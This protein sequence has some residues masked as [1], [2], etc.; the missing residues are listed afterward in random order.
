VNRPCPTEQVLLA[1]HQGTLPAGE[2]DA[3]ADHLESC[4]ACESAAQRLDASVDRVVAVVRKRAQAGSWTG[5]SRAMADARWLEVS[6]TD[7]T[8]W[9]K[10][11]GYEVLGLL[12]R[13]GMGIV[14]KARQVRLKRLVALK[15]LRISDSR[16]AARA[17]TEAEALARLTHPGIVQI[18]RVFEHAG[19]DYLALELVEGGSLRS[20]LD[21]KPLPPV[22]AATLIES[23][24]RAAHYAHSHDIVHRDLKPANILLP[25]PGGPGSGLGAPKIADFGVAKRLAASQGQTCDGD[26]LGTPAYMAPEQ[27]AGRGVDARSDVYSLGVILYELL[28]G[29]VPLQ[30]ETT[31]DTLILVRTQDPVSPRRL[32]PRLPRDLETVCLKC[33]EKDPDRRYASAQALA[34][35]LQ[36]FLNGE[37]IRARPTR[38]WERAWKWA[39]RRPTIAALIATVVLLVVVG[40]V[41]VTGLWW[42]AEDRADAALAATARAEAA[43]EDARDSLYR[44]LIAQARF[45]WRMNHADH[46]QQLLDACRPERRG[47]EWH[48]LS[49]I[50]RGSL[51]FF[52]DSDRALVTSVAF[53]PDGQLLAAVSWDPY[54]RGGFELPGLA[55]L[56]NLRTGRVVKSFP[57]PAMVDRVVFSPD[58]RYLVVSTN[59][60]DPSVLWDVPGFAVVRKWAAGGSVTFS[61]DSKHL[62]AATRDGLVFRDVRTGEVVRR[63]PATGG[64]ATVSPNGRDV[65]LSSAHGVEFRDAESGREVGRLNFGA[66]QH[67][68]QR[69]AF[70]APDGPDLAFSPDG[71]RIITATDPPKVWDRKTGVVCHEL[72]GHTGVVPGV[73]FGPDGRL[74]ATTGTDGFV[75]IWDAGTGRLRSQF[76]G[77]AGWVGCV[78]FHPEGWCLASGSHQPGDIKVWDL[79]RDPEYLTLA[80]TSSAALAFDADG[81]VANLTVVGR[82]ET[83]DPLAGDARVGGRIDLTLD[84]LTPARLADYS[85]DAKRVVT[86]SH[87]RR[88]IKVWDAGSGRELAALAGLTAPAQQVATDGTGRRVAA[89]GIAK[90]EDRYTADVR[91]WDAE[92]GR[93]LSSF[94]P[95]P[96]PGRTSKPAVAL[97]PAGDLVAFCASSPAGEDSGVRLSVHEVEGGRE[98]F[99]APITGGVVWSLAFSPDGRYLAAGNGPGKVFVFDVVAGILLFVGQ[100]EAT[101]FRLA[102]SPDGRRLAVVDREHVRVWDARVGQ[103]LLNLR[104]TPPR[105]ADNGFNP[106]VAWSPDGKRLAAGVWTGDVAV[107]DADEQ[108]ADATDRRGRAEVRAFGWHLAEADSA[109]RDRQ[110]AATAFHISRLRALDPPD[111]TSRL[112]RAHL[113][114]RTGATEPAAAD[115]SVGF[116]TI[117]SDEQGHYLEYGR[118]LVRR[119]ELDTYRRI[120]IAALE[121]ARVEEQVADMSAVARLCGLADGAVADHESAVAVAR[122]SRAHEPHSTHHRVSYALALYR[123]RRYAEAVAEATEAVKG[124]QGDEYVGRPVLALAEFRQGHTAEARRWLDLSAAE[125][126]KRSGRTDYFVD[127]KREDFSILYDEARRLID[128]KK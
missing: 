59:G 64:R 102:F 31:Y 12:G 71:D 60:R 11:P 61:A 46:A 125:V 56:W 76:P 127:G 82:L 13:G 104:G 50:N 65:A 43:K 121:V 21:G 86:I 20:R 70:F 18:Y 28:T 126:T 57:A 114:A 2:V 90:A 15:Q 122:Q 30:G 105:L 78:A 113:L 42:R 35:D 68:Y 9:P 52:R 112:R 111:V 98:V 109:L 85:G 110:P 93:E 67:T 117:S 79:T 1:F 119:G 33:L 58:G 73:A 38:V 74:A 27:A 128:G 36:R 53:S 124:N 115:Y 47:W 41:S 34:D 5:T 45:E 100:Q 25:A 88:V 89:A 4:P 120:C 99:A 39:K 97:S 123:A 92:T 75:R 17:R 29:R 7:P 22:E 19:V 55:E 107:W 48:Y 16:E 24:A 108:P 103:E 80:Q 54:A 116:R 8:T 72:G 51:L 101:V 106:T 44:G 95:D 23:L 118:I 10:P 84:W 91:V 77:Q 94:R 69:A 83:R 3:I 87:D 37:S 63:F 66:E 96:E 49:G 40:V 26:V 81:R 14:F 6:D 62:V 32:Q